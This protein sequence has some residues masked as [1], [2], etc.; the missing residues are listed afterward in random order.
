MRPY[1][2]NID[3]II[4]CF[5]TYCLPII[6][7]KVQLYTA[8]EGE[9]VSQINMMQFLKPLEVPKRHEPDQHIVFLVDLNCKNITEYLI[10]VRNV[11]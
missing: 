11:L 4:H 8:L 2:P 7:K 3:N 9:N 5:L 6:D 1:L 10:K